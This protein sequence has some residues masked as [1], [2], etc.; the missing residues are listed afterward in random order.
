M[1]EA[2]LAYSPA[3]KTRAQRA[4]QRRLR[5][6]SRAN[7]LDRLYG[8]DAE[9]ATRLAPTRYDLLT[10]ALGGHAE[11]AERPEE[12]APALERALASGRP[13]VVNVTLDP[14]AMKGHPYRGM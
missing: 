6:P 5:L 11:H 8:E 9:V 7:R 13:A 12:I 4:S 10:L 2:R 1:C 14:D 3:Q